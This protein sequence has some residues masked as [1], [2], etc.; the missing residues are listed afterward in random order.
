M[1]THTQRLQYQASPDR[2]DPVYAAKLQELIGGQYGEITVMMQYLFQGWNCRLPGKYKDMLHDIGTEEIGHVEMLATM[3]ARLMEGAPLDSPGHDE[4]SDPT[5]A[6]VIGGMDVQSAIVAGAGGRAVD[7]RG[8]LWNSGF[9]TSSGNL[10][11]D[12]HSNANAEMQG[13]LQATRLY[14]M[15]D[16][17]GVREMLAFL[18]ARDH[19]H[20]NQW[21]AAIEQLKT[22]GIEDLPVPSA[23]PLERETAE[24]GYQF[25]TFS[26]GEA[27]TQGR[28]AGGAAPDGTGELS[29]VP[30]PHPVDGVPGPPLSDPRL[31]ATTTP[32]LELPGSRV[33]A[34]AETER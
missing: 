30:G 2:S 26:D 16:D 10:M 14:N 29:A 27:S 9:I 17:P 20:Q 3:V 7:S 25:I 33:G 1:Y 8:N 34:D 12:F 15:T 28:W 4:V 13:R 5:V 31:F 19:M 18:I 23:F 11:A 6:A 32:D 21:L 22:D 24:V